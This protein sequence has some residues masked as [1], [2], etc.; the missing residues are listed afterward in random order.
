MPNPEIMNPQ[1]IIAGFNALVALVGSAMEKAKGLAI[2]LAP[3]KR[4]SSAI[5]RSLPVVQGTSITSSV[6]VDLG[7]APEAAAFEL[8]SGLHGRKQS[9]YMIA[10]KKAGGSLVFDWPNEDASA[11]H[12]HT[13]DGKVI[14]PYVN[15]PGI[16]AR[17]YLAPA[18][19]QSVD[20]SFRGGV[21]RIMDE[22]FGIGE[23]VV[24]EIK[25]SL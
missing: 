20:Q 2:S 18:V 3:T 16:A 8:G 24:I 12:P 9:K 19:E 15:H 6:Y 7:K 17:P 22:V 4:I 23:D 5:E 14:L 21:D 1:K 25:V 11:G 13:K 10:P